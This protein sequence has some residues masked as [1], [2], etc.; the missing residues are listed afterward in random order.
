MSILHIFL[1]MSQRQIQSQLWGQFLLSR[2]LEATNVFITEIEF[3][4]VAN[5]ELEALELSAH[6]A[7]VEV[8]SRV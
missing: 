5:V 7:S 3:S 6:T 8:Q 2:L 4:S 1:F